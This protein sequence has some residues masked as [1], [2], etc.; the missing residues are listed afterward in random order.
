MLNLKKLSKN[1]I[2]IAIIMALSIYFFSIIHAFATNDNYPV[3]SV[4]M[5]TLYENFHNERRILNENF[6]T[7]VNEVLRNHLDIITTLQNNLDDTNSEEIYEE[8]RTVKKNFHYIVEGMRKE[9]ENE[10]EIRRSVWETDLKAWFKNLNVQVTLTETQKVLGMSNIVQEGNIGIL[11]LKNGTEIEIGF[12]FHTL[13]PIAIEFETDYSLIHFMAG[14]GNTT[15]RIRLANS[16]KIITTRDSTLKIKM[17]EYGDHELYVTIG[18]FG[19]LIHSDGTISRLL[20][21]T[22]IDVKGNIVS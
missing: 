14:I 13:K 1:I 16:L 7:A 5:F 9:I 10:M 17:D 8:M 22:I 18:R 15:I 21:G 12:P 11:T 19:R 3:E 20:K 4:D 2:S 6:R